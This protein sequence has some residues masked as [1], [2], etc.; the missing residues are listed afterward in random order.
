MVCP[1]FGL[2]TGEA[3]NGNKIQVVRDLQ[4]H[5]PVLAIQLYNQVCYLY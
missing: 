3:S 2:E 1:K 4:H 5:T